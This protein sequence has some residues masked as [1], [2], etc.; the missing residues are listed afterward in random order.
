MT[1]KWYQ[2]C[3]MKRYYEQEK[4]DEKWVENYRLIFLFSILPYILNFILISTYPDYLDGAKNR[5]LGLKAFYRSGL[6][7]IKKL[8]FRLKDLRKG[9]INSG[10][11]VILL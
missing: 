6:D 10:V 11:A 7:S 8:I 2:V 4:I 1:C 3:P 5:K 9:I